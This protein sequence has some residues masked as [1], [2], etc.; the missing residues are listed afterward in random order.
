MMNYAARN[1]T[2]L[3]RLD[4]HAAHPSAAELKKAAENCFAVAQK[5]SNQ[6][7]EVVGDGRYSA[8]GKRAQL[9]EVRTK[10]ERLM[11]DARAP[12]D[13][14]MKGIERLRAQIKPP[15]IDRTDPVS[16]LRRAEIRAYMRSLPDAAR[17]AKM[18]SPQPDP[19]ILDAVLD[20]PAELSGVRAEDYAH[21]KAAREQQLHGPK[22]REIEA[23]QAVVGEADAAASVA[24]MDLANIAGVDNR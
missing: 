3:T 19:S 6:R 2:I 23:L 22:L 1:M 13:S 24:R 20:M 15:P 9:A 4:R 16:E 21:A 17:M 8:E 12:I 18:L 7:D 14:A 5:F 10:S 11:Q